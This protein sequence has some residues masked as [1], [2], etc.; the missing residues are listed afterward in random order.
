MVGLTQAPREASVA[1]EASITNYRALRYPPLQAGKSRGSQQEGPRGG[2]AFKS[3]I[4]H[5][6]GGDGQGVCGKVETRGPRNVEKKLSPK[7]RHRQLLE[8]KLRLLWLQ[9]RETH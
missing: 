1:R 2:A 7:G 5:G 9:K 3:E 8:V 6:Y 4:N